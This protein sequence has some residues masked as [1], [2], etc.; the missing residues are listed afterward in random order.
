MQALFNSCEIEVR[1]ITEFLAG[2][3]YGM[4]SS[5]VPGIGGV[6]RAV[7]GSDPSEQKG[8]S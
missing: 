5:E 1:E 8:L 2:A 4:Q 6:E 3:M 7:G